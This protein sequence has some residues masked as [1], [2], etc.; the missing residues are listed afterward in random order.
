[1]PELAPTALESLP[2]WAQWVIALCVLLGACIA[3]LGSWGLV[4]LKTYYERV[5][6]PAIIATLGS[7]LIMWASLVYYSF[8]EH[9]L[10]WH[11]LLI[12]LFIAVTV[13][14]STIFLMRAALFR[15]RRQGKA[16]PPSVSRTVVNTR[17][18][19]ADAHPAKPVATSSPLV[20]EGAAST[21]GTADAASTAE[22]A[23]PPPPPPP[24]P[25]AV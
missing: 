8:N 3:T 22:S 15:D 4:R 18:H 25:P 23:P 24:Q 12:A 21:A 17:L 13:P 20:V 1:M 19:E 2:L 7:W 16:V 9:T 14:I 6:T 5:H 11:T 10:A